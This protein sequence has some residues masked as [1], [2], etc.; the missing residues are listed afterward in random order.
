MLLSFRLDHNTQTISSTR[1]RENREPLLV[2]HFKRERKAFFIFKLQEKCRRNSYI[3]KCDRDKVFWRSTKTDSPE[4]TVTASGAYRIAITEDEKER[5]FNAFDCNNSDVD[6][7]DYNGKTAIMYSW[8]NQ[9]GTEF[10]AMAEYDGT[11]KE[12]LE[13]HFLK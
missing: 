11:L 12:L 4:Q 7:C 1:A 6:F 9:Y 2:L 5:I 13:S 8:G 10:L 3:A